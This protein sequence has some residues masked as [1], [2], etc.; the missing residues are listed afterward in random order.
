MARPATSG[1]P[2]PLLSGRRARHRRCLRPSTLTSFPFCCLP[3]LEVEAVEGVGT[4]TR[5]CVTR[6]RDT[7]LSDHRV[8]L[9]DGRGNL[10]RVRCPVHRVQGRY[11]LKPV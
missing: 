1:G 7:R 3:S 2:P 8:A 5:S 9:F 11:E 6:P 4:E 10:T